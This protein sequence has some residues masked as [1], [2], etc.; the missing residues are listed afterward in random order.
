MI[1]VYYDLETIKEA[2]DVVLKMDLIFKMLDNAIAQCSKCEEYGHYDYQCLS[3]SQHVRIVL[4][5][6]VDESKVV[7]DVQVPP[8]TFNIIKNIVVNSDTYY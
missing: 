2:F 8:K 5:D 7:E 4:T 1:I 3:N 6:E